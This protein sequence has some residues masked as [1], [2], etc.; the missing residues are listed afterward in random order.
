M[1][2]VKIMGGLGN[3]MFQ[4]AFGRS[5]GEQCSYDL[6]WFANIAA[7]PEE[8]VTFRKYALDSFA[9]S[10]KAASADD[11]DKL[12]QKSFLP[13]I[14]R[15]MIGA[16]KYPRF[17]QEK[18]SS[19]D[20]GLLKKRKNAYYEGYFQ[21]EKYFLSIREQLLKEFALALPLNEANQYMLQQIQNSNA[22]SLHVRRGDYV[23]FQ[24]SFGLCSVDYYVNAMKAISSK[25]I[26]PH[27]FVFSDDIEWV[28][29]NLPIPYVHTFVD[30]NSAHEG[31]FDIELMKHCKHNIIANS[32]FSWWGAWLNDNVNK[33]V[34]AP[35]VW[36][37]NGR[38]IDI[39]PNQWLQ[40]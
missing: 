18:D 39:I 5:H 17:I 14:I 26:T 34:V 36:F 25:V 33:I 37:A 13:K 12:K 29:S 20:A 21:C 31:H 11:C 35:K 30:N 27:F 38:K 2:I 7:T 23:K 6:S 24:A 22:V 8:N 16:R 32:S 40:L 1:N 15:K 10:L 9:L 19:F 3:Q 28:K 4:Y